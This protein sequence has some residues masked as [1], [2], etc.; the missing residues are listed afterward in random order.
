MKKENIKV[1]MERKEELIK[2]VDKYLSH[3][4][5]DENIHKH[6][7]CFDYVEKF[8]IDAVKGFIQFCK[9]NEMADKITPTIAH[10]INGTYDKYFFFCGFKCHIFKIEFIKH[11]IPL[12]LIN[13]I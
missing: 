8:G 11:F 10:D 13:M 12:F 6:M 1:N 4:K 7:T 5:W 9:D 2:V 3:W